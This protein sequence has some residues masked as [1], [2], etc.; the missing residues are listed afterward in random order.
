MA[1]AH[2]QKLGNGLEVVSHEH[3]DAAER[4]TGAP[5]PADYREFVTTLG[6]GQYNAGYIYVLM[7]RSILA[8]YEELRRT[9]HEHA[10]FWQD[11]ELLSAEELGQA[12]VLARTVDGDELVFHARKPGALYVLPRHGDEIYLAG[13]GLKDALEWVENSGVLVGRTR[14]SRL[15]AD[16]RWEHWTGATFRPHTNLQRAEFLC[17]AAGDLYAELMSRMTRQALADVEGTVLMTF[18][19]RDG[20]ADGA[21]EEVAALYLMECAGEIRCQ[22]YGESTVRVF[23]S[24][25]GTTRSRRMEEWLE[26]LASLAARSE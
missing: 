20:K 7:P 11:S 14:A 6:D 15:G 25:D 1:F 26:Y 21:D 17:Q 9:W 10:H 13:E 16:G 19:D 18:A 2:V 3:V 8:Q 12:I 4:L 23:V 22:P 5:F 24:Y